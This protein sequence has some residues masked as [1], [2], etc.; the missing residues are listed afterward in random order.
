FDDHVRL[1]LVDDLAES[2]VDELRAVDERLP[3]RRDELA[4]LLDRG[5]AEDG[6]GV[7]D[8]VDP[9]LTRRFLGLGRRPEP[10]QSLFEAVGLQPAGERLLDDEQ[11][12]VPAPLDRKSTRLNSSHVSTSYAVF[13][14]K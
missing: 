12:A 7:A 4:Q 1:D 14:L 9:E 8:E 11:D 2:I 10:H 13:C 5:L 6:R 3:G